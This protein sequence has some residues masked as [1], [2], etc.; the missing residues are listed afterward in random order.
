MKIAV[1]CSANSNISTIYFD[2]TIELGKY[3]AEN[4]HELVYG[5]CNMGLMECIAKC[6]KENGGHTIGVIPSKIEECGKISDYVDEHIFVHNLSERKDVM[7]DRA[8]IIIALPGGIGTLDEVFTVAAAATI[9]YHQKK[10]ILYNIGGFWDKLHATLLQMET[11]GFI[12]GK[13]NDYILFA[14]NLND[15]KRVLEQQ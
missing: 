5:G 4:G 9:G 14:S 2:R 1:F 15:I 10:V 8:D 11:D 13:M 12:R 7:L 3:M 6:V